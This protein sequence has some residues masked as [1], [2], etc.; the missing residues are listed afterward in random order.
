MSRAIDIFGFGTTAIFERDFDR[1]TDPQFTSLMSFNLANIPRKPTLMAPF[2]YAD[3]IKKKDR[4]FRSP[5]IANVR[6]LSST[7][8]HLAH[9]ELIGALQIIRLIVWGPKSVLKRVRGTKQTLCMRWG[10]KEV[11]SAMIA[12][13]CTFVSFLSIPFAE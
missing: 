6:A 9:G 12:L 1:Q 10:V 2:M 5:I 3:G 8:Y 4:L 13:A 11:T 7:E